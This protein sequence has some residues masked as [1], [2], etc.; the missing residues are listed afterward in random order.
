MYGFDCLDAVGLPIGEITSF[1]FLFFFFKKKMKKKERKK[2]E[3]II[4]SFS[5]SNRIS[6]LIKQ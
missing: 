6:C 5:P 4:L 1:L 2:K 3:K